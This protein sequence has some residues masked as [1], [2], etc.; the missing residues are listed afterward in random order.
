MASKITTQ[1]LIETAKTGAMK[2]CLRHAYDASEIESGDVTQRDAKAWYVEL[3]LNGWR[4]M[5]LVTD[6][7]SEGFRVWPS[8]K[9]RID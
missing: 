5:V 1:E 3:K 2:H 9:S 7:G 6:E 4:Y 8:S